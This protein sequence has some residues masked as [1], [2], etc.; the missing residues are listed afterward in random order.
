M[1]RVICPNDD[2]TNIIMLKLVF[3]LGFIKVISF[4]MIV[5]LLLRASHAVI[6]L[7]LSSSIATEY[8]FA[9]SGN[10]DT[11]LVGEEQ[12]LFYDDHGRMALL[13]LPFLSHFH[14][15]IRQF[16]TIFFALW[17]P[18]IANLRRV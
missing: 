5:T 4:R 12:F 8:I 11:S 1:Q 14:H 17:F 6:S 10:D 2:V 3:M 16:K 15:W 9:P 18:T 13:Q 7:Q